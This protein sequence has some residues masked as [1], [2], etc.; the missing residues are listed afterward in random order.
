MRQIILD[1]ETTGLSAANGDRLIEIG[2]LE[3]VS[4]KL[5]GHNYHVYLN[6]DRD[7]H[8]DALRVHGLT[9]EFLSDKPRFADVA[10]DFLAYVEG[11]ELIIHNAT[12]DVGF[13][14]AELALL[15]L[16]AL[17]TRVSSITDTLHMAKMA[18]PG[19]RNS[20]DAL[21][22]RFGVDRTSRTLHGA[23]L[24]AELLVDVYIHLTR[25]QE[26]LL[27]ESTPSETP[28]VKTQAV[29]LSAWVLPV[30]QANESER[31]AHEEALALLDNKSK[32]KT[33]WRR[34]ESA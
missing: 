1:T 33:V 6:P 9:R 29:D 25:G 5:T 30:V 19:K 22:D 21:C 13:I 16:P 18:Y 11:A 15:G 12:F 20:L 7:S 3:L 26:N 17:H 4:R 24:D 31:A 34:W 23:L 10:Q 2:C 28:G 27:I 8:E 32:G 14:D